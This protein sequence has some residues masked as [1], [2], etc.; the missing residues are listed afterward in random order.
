MVIW[1]SGLKNEDSRSTSALSLDMKYLG[2][3]QVGNT[4]VHTFARNE[5]HANV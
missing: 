4:V 3:R 2:T 5:K 1:A